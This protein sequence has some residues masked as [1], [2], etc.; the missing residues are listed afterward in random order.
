DP[1]T[2]ALLSDACRRVG[3]FAIVGHGIPQSLVTDVFAAAH[4]LFALPAD[5]KLAL[6]GDM[7]AGNCGYVPLGG[8]RLSA[9]L[10]PDHKEA[11]NIGPEFTAD[12]PRN[13]WPDLP[14]WR[15]TMQAYFAGCH[16]LGRDL[17]RALAGD[18]GVRGDFF[19]ACLE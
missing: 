10:P 17:H 15:E 5:L 9:D 14:G 13:L 7:M 1:A 12:A 18:L 4:A 6:R 3:F 19:D 16:A 11:Y 8:E 2:M